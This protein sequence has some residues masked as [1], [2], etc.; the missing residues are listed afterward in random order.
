[1][2]AEFPIPEG[3]RFSVCS[4]ALPFFRLLLWGISVRRQIHEIKPDIV[5]VHSV[6]TYGALALLSVPSR[7]PMVL[8]AWG[9]DVLMGRRHFLRRLVLK[10]VLGRAKVVTCDASHMESALVALG[11]PKSRIHIVNFGID[12][13]TFQFK[14]SRQAIRSRLGLE[15]G[16]VVVSLRSFEPVYDIPTLVHAARDVLKA[17]PDARFVLFGKGSLETTLRNLVRELGLEGA[18]QFGGFIP[19]HE[20]ADYLSAIDVYVSTSLSD[21]GIAAST[22]EAMACQTP[23]VVTSTGENGLWIDGQ[24]GLLVPASDPV[25]L[26]NAIV[27][28]L[29]DPHFRLSAGA[30]GRETILSRNDYHNEMKKVEAIYSG[31]LS[32]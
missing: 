6:G 12:T 18:I 14:N 20:L 17:V 11:V 22:A 4:R 32:S 16:P 26:A 19:N 2:A 25:A 1:M 9:S 8:T 5:H 21:A 27:R 3:I 24:N 23:V 29:E 7:V 15:G 10:W 28:L 30:A 13:T 31:G